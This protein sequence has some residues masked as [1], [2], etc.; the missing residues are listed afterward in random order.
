MTTPTKHVLHSHLEAARTGVEAIMRDYT[1]DSVLISQDATYR[2]RREIRGFF[3]VLFDALPERFF[4]HATIDRQE[5][6]GEVAYILWQAQPWIPQ[7]T[8]TFVVR[9]G[10]ILF[11]T[12]T[13]QLAR[14]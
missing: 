10:T 1:D 11:Q 9:D 7:A 8:D 14:A 5:I 3:E 13:A 12:V 4:D 6:V 2:G